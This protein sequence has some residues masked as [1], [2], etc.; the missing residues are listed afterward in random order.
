MKIFKNRLFEKK[1]DNWEPFNVC[2]RLETI[3]KFLYTRARRPSNVGKNVMRLLIRFSFLPGTWDNRE[4]FILQSPK[5]VERG[6]MSGL[7]KNSF[8]SLCF[9]IENQNDSVKQNKIRH[10]LTLFLENFYN[11]I[12]TWRKFKRILQLFL[13]ITIENH[14]FE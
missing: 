8:S 3:E 11:E 6:K 10:L 1:C 9:S 5:P 7:S 14:S 2:P 12:W 13:E 4:I